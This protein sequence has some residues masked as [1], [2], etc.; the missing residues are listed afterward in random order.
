[1]FE[2]F[3]VDL[4]EAA[5]DAEVGADLFAHLDEGADEVEAHLHGLFAAE[6]GGGHEAAVLGEGPRQ[7]AESTMAAT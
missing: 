6:D 7:S 1:M 4:G 5:E 3:F 2:E